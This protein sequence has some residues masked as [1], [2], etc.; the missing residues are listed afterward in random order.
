MT[1]PRIGCSKQGG[2][3]VKE[4]LVVTKRDLLI[5]SGIEQVNQ[6][7]ATLVEASQ[8]MRKS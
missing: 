5:I 2:S 6:G 1:P 8:M 4:A 3:A 7:K